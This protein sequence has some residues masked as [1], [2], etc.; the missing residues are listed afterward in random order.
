M[1]M[2]IYY[3]HKATNGMWKNYLECGLLLVCCIVEGWFLYMDSREFDGIVVL[4]N[5]FMP[6]CIVTV[7][8]SFFLYKWKQ[9]QVILYK[10]E[11][12]NK[13]IFVVLIGFFCYLGAI[14]IGMFTFDY[15][16]LL[17]ILSI[18]IILYIAIVQKILERSYRWKL[19][20]AYILVFAILFFKV[21]LMQVSDIVT[22][23][24]CDFEN[25]LMAAIP[26][27]IAVAIG[28]LIAWLSDKRRDSGL[29][30]QEAEDMESDWDW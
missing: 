18:F 17:R 21:C 16:L 4:G 8:L 30:K 12:V 9:G 14:V 29:A 27:G 24:Y 19:F 7:L 5:R 10:M 28:E 22:Y 25:F 26:Y 3:F 2:I 1:I 13:S 11:K 23:G 6:I 20:H 15:Q